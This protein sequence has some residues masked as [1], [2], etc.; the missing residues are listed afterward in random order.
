MAFLMAMLMILN[1]NI[2]V[3]AEV[4]G[5]DSGKENKIYLYNEAFEGTVVPTGF[6]GDG[7]IDTDNQVLKLDESGTTSISVTPVEGITT[8]T[9]EFDM[10]RLDTYA[11][12]TNNYMQLIM[13]DS[14]ENEMC[15]F[16]TQNSNLRIKYYDE[17]L[18]K[19]QYR[20]LWTNNVK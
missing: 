6:S 9:V 11:A 18:A 19:N 15:M 17:S 1:Q 7:T 12:S 16:D 2:L 14:S 8:Y 4:S 13:R 3:R 5:G 10:M 20:N